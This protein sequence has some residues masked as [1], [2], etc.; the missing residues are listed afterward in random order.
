[1][2]FSQD[3]IIKVVQVSSMKV[4]FSRFTTNMGNIYVSSSKSHLNWSAPSCC[5]FEQG[6]QEF[7]N[8]MEIKS[9]YVIHIKDFSSSLLSLLYARLICISQHFLFSKSIWILI[10]SDQC[11]GGI[12]QWDCDWIRIFSVYLFFLQPITNLLHNLNLVFANVMMF[13]SEQ[14]NKFSVNHCF[15]QTIDNS[16]VSTFYLQ[17]NCKP[18]YF[19]LNCCLGFCY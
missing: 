9:H 5:T 19:L 4:Q 2:G 18:Y 14:N 8:K 12:M 1:M 16:T 7:L 15:Q 11:R 13:A 6:K 17:T 10:T 3:L